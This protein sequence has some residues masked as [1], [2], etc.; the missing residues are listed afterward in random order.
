MIEGGSEVMRDFSYDNRP[1]QGRL[2]LA[3]GSR[4]ER[5]F[6]SLRVTLGYDNSISVSFQEAVDFP[7]QVVDLSLCLIKLSD[8]SPKRMH[9]IDLDYGREEDAEDAKR[10]RD[11]G[12]QAVG[13]HA[14]PHEGREALSSRHR[15]E[16]ASRTERCHPGG[17]YKG[18]RNR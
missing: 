17:D 7:F 8:R 13:L 16:V 15:E 3:G 4:P 6:A 11:T 9:E 18:M 14:R 1:S 5:I 10:P 12:A 2:G